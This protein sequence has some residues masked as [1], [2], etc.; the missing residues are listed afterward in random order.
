M[1]LLN[2]MT[3]AL[4]TIQ[5][6]TVAAVS[7]ALMNTALAPAVAT[8]ASSRITRVDAWAL[9]P[10]T[11]SRARTR[12]AEVWRRGAASSFHAATR[13]SM[14]TALAMRVASTRG[15][16]IETTRFCRSAS[17]RAR[18]VR[19]RASEDVAVDGDAKRAIKQKLIRLCAR[20][21]GGK[22][23][24]SSEREELERLVSELTKIGRSEGVELTR[25]NGKWSLLATLA[26]SEDARERRAREGA[27]GSA[28]TEI[29]GAG[30]AVSE[31][32]GD[33]VSSSSSSFPKF[34]ASKGNYQDID[35]DSGV[36]ENRAELALFG[37]VPLTVRLKASCVASPNG[38]AR[39]DVA[40]DAVEISLGGAG[41]LS[42]SLAF[43]NPRGW[44]ETTYVDDD[45]RTGKGDKGSIFIAA[46]RQ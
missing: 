46:R 9:R 12:G 16:S 40:F 11:G 25:V 8:L 14:A 22:R 39:L 18:A 29:S 19:A 10:R 6:L 44:I 26:T 35:V 13:A 32:R 15:D 38:T 2:K 4:K 3:P 7:A 30:G 33:G 31:E 28:L 17:R 24:T 37:K 5:T 43:A 41:P 34:I 20:T 21:D 45:I 27:I 23:A 1:Y 42:M 36:A